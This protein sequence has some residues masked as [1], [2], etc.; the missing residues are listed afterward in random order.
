MYVHA[1]EYAKEI[2]IWV[3]CKPEGTTPTYD[4][5]ISE[6]KKRWPGINKENAE[7]IFEK[8]IHLV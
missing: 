3:K 8:T 6:I 1:N 4:Q 2:A 5:I 7:I